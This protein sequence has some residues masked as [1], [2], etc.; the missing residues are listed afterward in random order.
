MKH[1][2][3]LTSKE[4]RTINHA[5]AYYEAAQDDELD[6]ETGRWSSRAEL[7]EHRALMR[8]RDKVLEEIRKSSSR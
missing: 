4:L 5:L 3:Q 2:L 7:E 6:V 1:I 8:A